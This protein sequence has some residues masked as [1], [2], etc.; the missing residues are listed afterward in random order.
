MDLHSATKDYRQVE[1]RLIDALAAIGDFPAHGGQGLLRTRRAPSPPGRHRR[2]PRGLRQGTRAQ[3]GPATR[4]GAAALP[5]RR[6]RRRREPTCGCGWTPSRTTSTASGCCPPPSRSRWPATGSTR[7]TS[8]APNWRKRAERFDSPGFRA[9]ARHARGAVLVKQ[10]RE[11]EALPVL[12]DAL[13]RYRSTQCRYEMAQVY[14]WMSLA[15]PGD[16]RQRRRR[17]RHRQR[18]RPSTSS[19]APC[20]AR[21][22]QLTQRPAA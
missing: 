21:R 8:T 3:Q 11:A 20:P 18:R 19:S 12:Q 4:R 10:G 5:T 13:R 1:E 17:L 2:R 7:P 9:W 22:C 15:P 6:G 14:E 16:R